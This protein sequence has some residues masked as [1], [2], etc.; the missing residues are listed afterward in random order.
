[1]LADPGQDNRQVYVNGAFVPA[2]EATISVFDRGF[3]MADAVYE[4]TAVVGGKLVD[5]TCHM[6]RLH[7]SLEALEIPDPHSLDAWRELHRAV[8][9][10]NSLAEGLVYVQVSRGSTGERDIARP[11]VDPSPTVVL[12]SRSIP[13]FMTPL[14]MHTGLKIMSVPDLRWGRCDIKSVQLIYTSMAKLIAK[15]SGVNDVWYVDNGIVTEGTSHNAGIVVGREIITHPADAGILPGV[16]RAALIR[17][18]R[19][20][21]YQVSERGFALEEAYA[22]SEAFATAAMSYFLPIVQIDGRR[23]GTGT[24]GETVRKLRRIYAEEA[25]RHAE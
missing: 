2:G 23:I 25:L 9:A 8:V 4:V 20:E 12:F 17:L 19:E 5:L 10:R 11:E 24:P 14:S 16:T 3:L 1:M 18:A 22:A 6:N 13:G 21:G 15:R 7:Q